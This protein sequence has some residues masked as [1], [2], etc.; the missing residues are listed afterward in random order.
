MK[1]RGTGARRSGAGLCFFTAQQRN[2]FIAFRVQ[3]LEMKA[4]ALLLFGC[5]KG[6]R[7]ENRC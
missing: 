1:A 7:S 4:L 3:A 6:W 2:H 5:V